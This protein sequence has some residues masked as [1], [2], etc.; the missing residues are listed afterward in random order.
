M[1]NLNSSFALFFTLLALAF[2]N[3]SA[4]KS[5]GI[6]NTNPSKKA[7]LHIKNDGSSK[8]GIIIPKLS[9]F[10]TTLLKS[11]LTNA[12]KGL[13]FYDT[14]NSVYQYW[15]GTQW[16]SFGGKSTSSSSPWTQSGTYIYPTTLT[17]NV[18]I[19]TN[20]PLSLLQI[21]SEFHVLDKTNTGFNGL[22]V[23]AISSGSEKFIYQEDG[24]ATLMTLDQPYTGFFLFPSGTK[25]S[26][27]SEYNMNLKVTPTGV[28]IKCDGV[29]AFLDLR[30]GKDAINLPNGLTAE[31]PLVPNFGA[32]RFNTETNAFEG[33]N[34][35]GWN[36]FQTGTVSSPWTISGT[37]IYN[38][39]TGNVGIGSTNATTKLFVFSPGA[40]R[41][42]IDGSFT[43]SSTSSG[44]NLMTLGDGSASSGATTKKWEIAAL[45]DGYSSV[46][47]QNGLNYTFWTG[48]S[49][50]TRLR[51]QSNGRI[52]IGTVSPAN[53]LDVAGSMAIGTTYAGTTAAPT[54]G[55]I[56]QGNVG[57]GTN[58]PAT[59]NKLEVNG[60]TRLAGDLNIDATQPTLRW[61]NA[62]GTQ[63][64]YIQHNTNL[65][66]DASSG[67]IT[68]GGNNLYIDNTNNRV[69][70]GTAT[71]STTLEVAGSFSAAYKV[72]T[73]ANYTISDSDYYLRL[74]NAA[75]NV[76]LPNSATYPGRTLIIRKHGVVATHTLLGVIKDGSTTYSTSYVFSSSQQTMTLIA[77]PLYGWIVTSL[78]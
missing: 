53:L 3:V 78:R 37:N 62:A 1:K 45:N 77:D 19:G 10:D 48:N 52:G 18:G 72:V 36:D 69:G 41:V 26:E 22:S 55:L 35:T 68:I 33:Y 66:I 27:L 9:G 40:A 58:A 65:Q 39:N 67:D 17:N 61:R 46:A 57:I 76:T 42:T 75:S 44:I 8:Q 47:D 4:Q 12:E 15:N 5:T 74:D 54:N 25:G 2:S 6:N 64:G 11:G 63:L 70:I 7:A 23:N 24:V 51:I 29:N 56:V 20:K 38:N 16:F 34:G 32:F 60:T 59:G 50:T 31:R 21:G 43:G 13:V 30:N 49:G 28:G 14:T 73:T 71:P